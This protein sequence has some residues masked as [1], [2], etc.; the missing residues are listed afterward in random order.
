M[1]IYKG[2]INSSFKD[3]H[4]AVLDIIELLRTKCEIADRELL[5]NINFMLREV[6]NNAVEHGNKYDENKKVYCDVLYEDNVLIFEVADEGEGIDIE[7]NPFNANKDYVLRERNRGIKVI[8]DLNFKISIDGNKI[9]L[10][11]EI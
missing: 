10:E 1:N 2:I 11:L 9:R 8:M 5:F 6:M 7:A 4:L 3:V